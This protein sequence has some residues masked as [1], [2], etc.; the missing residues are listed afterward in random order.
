VRQTVQVHFEK[1]NY[2]H[3]GGGTFSLKFHQFNF[4]IRSFT[5]LRSLTPF[6]LIDKG[7]SPI[8]LTFYLL[9][10]VSLIFIVVGS[11]FLPAC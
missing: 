10:L 7:G 3:F 8:F 6:L 11:L 4:H 5:S 9:S 2:F 1:Y